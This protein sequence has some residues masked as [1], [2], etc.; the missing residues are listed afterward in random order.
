[1]EIH[2]TRPG[3]FRPQNSFSDLDD[4]STLKTTQQK[5]CTSCG[6]PLILAGRYLPVRLL[7][8]GGFGAAFLARDR[9]T[10]TMRY[11]FVKQF[12]PIGNLNE[13]QL[14]IAQSLFEREATVLEDLGNQNKKIPDLYAF[15]PLIAPARQGKK[16]EQYFYLVQQF[17]DGQTLEEELA[18]KGQ[19]SE[20]EVREV[21]LE[22]LDVLAFVHQNNTIHRDI[23]PS[24]IMRDKNGRL[25]LLDFGAVKQVTA[26][27]TPSG[28]ST[29]I[30]SMGFAP[31]EQMSGSQVYPSTDMYAL[32]ATCLNLLTGRKPEELYDSFNYCWNWKTYAPQTSARLASVFDRMLLQT[33]KDRFQS[34]EE[35]LNALNSK[36]LPPQQGV[37]TQLQPPLVQS[38]TQKGQSPVIS[39]PPTPPV[40]RRSFSLLELLG[41]AAFTGFEGV[42]FYI[43]LTNLL[44]SPGVSIGLLGMCLGGIIFALSRRFIEGKDLPILAGLTFLLMLVPLL[45]GGWAIAAIAIFAALGGVAAVAVTALFRL[46]YKILARF[47]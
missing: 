46:I 18:T 20:A 10:P 42:L 6:M 30:Y 37:N 3:C 26:G 25:Y 31:P 44:P 17:I 38:G 19:F 32:A 33:P 9:Y 23:K 27:N 24:N 7:G 40:K 47:L 15:F 13:E 35:V 34:A 41:N 21:L 4:L 28:R 1:M 2:C 45:R 29:G 36:S 8:Q 39:P 14:E 16:E 12:Q 43:V 11:C 5:Y 22:M